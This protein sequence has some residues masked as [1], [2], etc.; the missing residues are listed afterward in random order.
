LGNR[1]LVGALGAE[2]RNCVQVHT[3]L[4]GYM[5]AVV[6]KPVTTGGIMVSY[7][8]YISELFGNI[9]NCGPFCRHLL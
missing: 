6:K 9:Q 8:P 1:V 7:I 3:R 4:C 2:V 5:G